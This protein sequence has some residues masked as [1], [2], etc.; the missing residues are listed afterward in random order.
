MY[1]ATHTEL[2][3]IQ[4]LKKFVL[5]KMVVFF[6]FW[7]GFLLSILGHFQLIG[8]REWTT[9]ETKQLASGIQDV[10]V[11]IEC[12]PLALAFAISFPARDYMRPGERPATLFENIVNMFDARDL[13][14][15][16]GELVEDRVR[17]WPSRYPQQS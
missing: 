12:L 3:D 6:T 7:Q 17:F 11:C 4:P 13:G 5:I 9:Y 16:V 10:I 8:S 1:Y 2:A 15:D 14:R